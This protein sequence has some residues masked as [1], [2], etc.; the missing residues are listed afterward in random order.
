VI[1]NLQGW[2]IEP[3]AAELEQ[4]KVRASALGAKQ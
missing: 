2:L 3:D 1:D 4:S